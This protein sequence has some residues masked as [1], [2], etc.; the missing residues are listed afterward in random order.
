M[1]VLRASSY[2]T[3]RRGR[4]DDDAIL[5]IKAL[6]KRFAGLVATNDLSL[7]VMPGETHAV[8]WPQRCGQDHAHRAIAGRTVAD[9]GAI[10][11]NGKNITR[12][13]A[14]RRAHLGIARSFSDYF[15][16]SA[17]HR[18]GECCA[19]SASAAGT[20]LPLFSA[21]HG[22]ILRLLSRR[23]KPWT[24]S[25]L[26]IAPRS[27]RKTFRTERAA[28][29]RTRDGACNE[30]AAPPA[31]RSRWRAWAAGRTAHDQSAVGSQETLRHPAGR[32]RHGCRFS[33]FCGSH[34]RSRRR[35]YDRDGIAR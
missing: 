3:G 20:Q 16:L 26:L 34:Q 4:I 17:V 25:G 14:H 12:E 8:I 13:P 23:V 11:F 1:A 2:A 7:D 29:A 5:E 32:T 15:D 35:A 22:M 31:G 6:H 10:F 30:A 28:A 24:R 9:G 18:A 19:R 27:M 33:R 21:L